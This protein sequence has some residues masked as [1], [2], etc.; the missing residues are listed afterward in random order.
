MRRHER[1]V[2]GRSDSSSDHGARTDGIPGTPVPD[3]VSASAKSA[4]L[5]TS[6][7]EVCP[8]DLARSEQHTAG[9]PSGPGRDASGH[10]V[11][12]AVVPAATTMPQPGEFPSTTVS[13]RSDHAVIR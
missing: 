13:R 6:P 9:T 12:C 5:L 8:M 2:S 3:A 11:L 10:A 1:R 7:P 4:T